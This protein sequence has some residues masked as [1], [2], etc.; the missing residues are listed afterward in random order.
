[1][2]G[3][4]DVLSLQQ[5]AADLVLRNIAVLPRS[6]DIAAHLQRRQLSTDCGSA[7]TPLLSLGTCTSSPDCDCPVLIV[8]G[9]ACVTCVRPVNAT[10]ATQ[11]DQ[12]NLECKK[13][14]ISITSPTRTSSPPSQ[15]TGTP[16]PAACTSA[17][18]AII[19]A[20]PCLDGGFACNCDIISTEG[21]IVL[22]PSNP[23]DNF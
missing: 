11:I 21:P 16:S 7:C 23:I 10:L 19:S 1:M 6:Q 9:S 8:S 18:G 5:A 20:P 12:L 15:V 13:G 2:L 4:A 17:C 3:T 22:F 14:S